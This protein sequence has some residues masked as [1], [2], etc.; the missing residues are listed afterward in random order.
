[1]KRVENT[2]KINLRYYVKYGCHY[3]GLYKTHK[4]QR[5]YAEI[6]YTEFRPDRSRDVEVTGRNSFYVLR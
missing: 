1:M 3:T 4:A 5:H 6:F 2:E